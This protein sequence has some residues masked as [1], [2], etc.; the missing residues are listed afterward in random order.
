MGRPLCDS[1]NS[2]TFC[3]QKFAKAEFQP[4][5]RHGGQEGRGPRYKAER[6]YLVM[7]FP[8]HSLCSGRSAPAPF[9]VVAEQGT[10]Q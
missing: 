1:K 3:P 10:G 5:F 8:Y 2:Q 4:P 6:F 7:V 9:P